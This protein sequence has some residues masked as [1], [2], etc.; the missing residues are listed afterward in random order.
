M[1]NIDSGTYNALCRGLPPENAH[2]IPLQYIVPYK[3]QPPYEEQFPK[4]MQMC[5]F[6]GSFH[7]TCEPIHSLL[8]VYSV[9]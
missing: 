5:P 3:G 6:V 9:I 4:S 7:Y 8:C 1:L 2:Y